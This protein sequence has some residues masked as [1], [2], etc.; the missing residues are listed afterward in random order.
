LMEDMPHRDMRMNC[1][2][3]SWWRSI[4]TCM[5]IFARRICNP[6]ALIPNDRTVHNQGFPREFPVWERKQ[7]THCRFLPGNLVWATGVTADRSPCVWTMDV[8]RRTVRYGHR[9][10]QTRAETENGSV[11]SAAGSCLKREL[12]YVCAIVHFFS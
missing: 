11:N 6:A 9:R 4:V 8:Q 5:K 10:H 2:P 7:W 12:P 1:E 3:I